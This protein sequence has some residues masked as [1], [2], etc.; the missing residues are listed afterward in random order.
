METRPDHLPE[1]DVGALERWRRHPQRLNLAT[2]ALQSL[3]L[4]ILAFM[5]FAT[6]YV[7][8]G[9]FTRM[10]DGDPLPTYSRCVYG[11][12]PGEI[13]GMVC[14]A[15]MVGATYAAA[16]LMMIRRASSVLHATQ[17]VLVLSAITWAAVFLVFATIMAAIAWPFVCSIGI[18][19]TDQDL[20]EEKHAALLWLGG[21]AL[22]GAVLGAWFT[23]NWRA[24][25]RE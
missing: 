17:R 13:T 4:F 25:P 7:W 12:L 10:M 24:R 15:L 20:S 3:C 5:L 11:I 14:L 19:L 21:T 1:R 2:V 22:Y 8:D 6:L 16:G 23:W 9:R 18:L